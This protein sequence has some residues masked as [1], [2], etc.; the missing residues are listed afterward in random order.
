MDEDT[1][2]FI[3]KSHDHNACSSNNTGTQSANKCNKGVPVQQDAEDWDMES[4]D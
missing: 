3:K 4:D 2:D 1:Q